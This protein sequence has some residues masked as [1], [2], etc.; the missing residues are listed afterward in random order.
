MVKFID[1]LRAR[2]TN[3]ECIPLTSEQQAEFIRFTACTA[4]KLAK[5]HAFAAAQL[6]I[7]VQDYKDYKEATT[8]PAETRADS[9]PAPK[10]VV[11]VA[12]PAKP[13]RGPSRS[14]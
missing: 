7:A 11:Q 8:A 12:A 10:S 3:P 9:A 1:D 6:S 13:R 5:S 4:V 2:S 14:D